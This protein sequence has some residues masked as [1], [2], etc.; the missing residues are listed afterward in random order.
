[1]LASAA[2]GGG[3][4][5]A[6]AT[7]PHAGEAHSLAALTKMAYNSQAIFALCSWPFSLKLLWAPIVD[8]CF[9]KR[10]G[11]RK[12]WLVPIQLIAGMLMVGG[13]DYVERELGLDAGVADGGS[14][15]AEMH[16]QGVTAFFF[17]LYFLMA[18]QGE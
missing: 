10:F 7:Q 18:T 4:A 9:S 14:A 16:V 8:A 3:G 13:S 2:G 12:S 1:M 11:R 15:V 5:A 6:A 17:T